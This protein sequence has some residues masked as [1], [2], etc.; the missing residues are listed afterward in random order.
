MPRVRVVVIGSGLQGVASA[1]FLAQEGCDVTVLERAPA[2]AQGTSYANAGML[3]PSMADPWNAPGILGHVLGQ[4]GHED[5]PF[6]LRLRALPS[7]VGWGLAFLAN[8]RA[9]PFRANME[10]N[11][12]LASYSLALLRTLRA[13]LGLHYDQRTAGTIKVFRERRAFD[14]AV[15]RNAVLAELGLDVRTLAPDE[16]VRTEPALAGVREK[17][18][19]GIYCPA[20]ESGDARLFTEGLARKAQEAGAR[21][22]FGAEVS[23]FET[24]GGRIAAVV[25]TRGRRAAEAF[26]LAAGVWS[27]LLLQPLG[28]ALRLRPVKGYSITVPIGA[29]QAAPRMPVIDDALH[30]AATPLGD[31]LRVAGTAELAGYDT[32]LTPGRVEN[33]FTLLLGL[34]P[35]YAPYLDRAAASPWAG[36]RPVSADGVPLIGRYRYDNLFLNT[37]HG[38]LGWTLACGSARLLADL[39]LGRAPGVDARA[40][41]AQRAL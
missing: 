35:S 30:T 5:A 27:P 38:H 34:F 2:V 32:T 21:F 4:L 41:D 13:E 9:R 7:L 36:L 17:L 6:L 25:T 3:T 19:G 28:F 18:A 14:A 33:L 39:M 20:D 8:A 29:W 23:G 10:R 11:L 37:G 26:V 22:E 40:Y 16:V 31:R 24:A 1:W 15:R 12:R